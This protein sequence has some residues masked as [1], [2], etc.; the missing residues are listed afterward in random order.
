MFKWSDSLGDNFQAPSHKQLKSEV[1]VQ[2]V[3]DANMFSS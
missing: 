3:Q 2:M 1:L